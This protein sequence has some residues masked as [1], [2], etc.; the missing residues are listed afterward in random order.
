MLDSHMRGVLEKIIDQVI[1]SIPRLQSSVREEGKDKLQIK[2]EE[3]YM[4]GFVHGA[5]MSDFVT[6]FSAM[7]K[8][9][10][11]LEENEEAQAVAFNRTAEVCA[12]IR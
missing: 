7:N 9:S 2:N 4:L 5:I 12:C 6:T 3:D 11:N 8:R 1:T 10:I